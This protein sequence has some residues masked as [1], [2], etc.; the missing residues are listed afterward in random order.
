MIAVFGFQYTFVRPLLEPDELPQSVPAKGTVTNP[1]SAHAAFN[2]E[3][4]QYV[5]RS[6]VRTWKKRDFLIVL[7]IPSIDMD[8][9]RRRRY[10]QRTSCWRFSGV[11]T[12]ANNFSGA[13]LVLYV[14]A[15]HPSHNFTYS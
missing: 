2:S 4:L 10:L 14:L 1:R 12:R 5:P 9:R 7:G 11:A 3:S 13:M 6:V 15:R 8:V